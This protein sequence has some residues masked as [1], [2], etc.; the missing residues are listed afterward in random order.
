M[1]GVNTVWLPLEDLGKEIAIYGKSTK[2]VFYA[3]YDGL[4]LVEGFVTKGNVLVEIKK[5]QVTIT[6]GT[7]THKFTFIASPL[8]SPANAMVMVDNPLATWLVLI[9]YVDITEKDYIE[10]YKEIMD[11]GG[12]RKPED[13]Y[14][15]LVAKIMGELPEE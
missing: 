7:K 11:N 9:D 13:S 1:A 3:M 2:L 10:L 8:I 5:D 6:A 15:D 14:H 4:E 12:Y